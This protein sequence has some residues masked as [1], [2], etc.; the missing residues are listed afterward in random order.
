M[1]DRRATIILLRLQLF[2]VFI[3]LSAAATAQ[4]K[5]ELRNLFTQA[6]SHFLYGEY[7]MAN[8]IYLTLG[9]FEPDNYNVLYKIGECYLNIPD[10]KGKAIEFLEKAVKNSDLEANPDQFKE[11]RAPIDAYFSLARAYMI[12]ND[13]E[14]ALST[15]QVFQKMLAE[16]K[17]KGGL[18]NTEFIDQ[19]I[20]ACKNARNSCCI[21]QDQDARRILP[22]LSQRGSCSQL[23]RKYNSLHGEARYFKCNILFKEGKRKVAESC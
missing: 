4:K 23:R 20:V 17:Q 1:F 10:E 6:E 14:K 16:T 19:Q 13:L 9:A 15:L 22:W 2:A 11:K 8:P 5:S 7:E 18:E 21:Q 3:F 12:N